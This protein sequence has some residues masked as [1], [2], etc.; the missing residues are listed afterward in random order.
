MQLDLGG[1]IVASL[2]FED[3][4]PGTPDPYADN[5][6]F[7]NYDMR[8][9]TTAIIQ[10]NGSLIKGYSYD[11]FG[12]LEQTG[13]SGFLNEVTYTGSVTDTSTG[14]QYMNA[15]FYN[16]STGRFLSQDSY[17]GNAYD[18][19]TQ[20]LY[21]YTGNNPV[22]F[23]DPTGHFAILAALGIVSLVTAIVGLISTPAVVEASKP[24]SKAITNV[25]ERKIESDKKISSSM[26]KLGMAAWFLTFGGSSAASSNKVDDVIG[27]DGTI[28]V[29]PPAKK[30][31]NK[32][33]TK[34]KAEGK[35]IPIAD[36][37]TDT[38]EPPKGQTV[39]RLYGGDA[40][41]EGSS[42][43]PVNPMLTSDFRGKSG[44]PSGKESGA[45]NT[46]AYMAIGKLVDPSG[47]KQIKWAD[48]LDGNPGGRIIEYVMYQP[49]TRYIQIIAIVPT[50]DMF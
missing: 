26:Y 30:T 6:Y 42:W 11:E 25:V 34:P 7:Y 40:H 43:T 46:A 33:Q 5:Y 49:V 18:P 10:P 29:N 31:T 13:A 16:P 2:R 23:V 32:S 17:K 27:G 41:L 28:T 1:N 8:G 39:Y 44:L 15:R 4:D 45:Y 12:Q 37:V 47:I 20:H 21:A 14:L 19:W 36:S 3:Q 22:N 9:S 48:P 35:D 38:S 50:K 24:I